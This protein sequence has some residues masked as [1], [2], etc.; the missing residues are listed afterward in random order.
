MIFP[1]LSL[2]I[3]A[4]ELEQK[5]KPT[6]YIL[7]TDINVCTQTKGV[8]PKEAL[9]PTMAQIRRLYRLHKFMCKRIGQVW[10]VSENMP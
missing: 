10:C 4:Y 1:N 2:N 9:C 7:G 6:T 3:D 8:D 5:V